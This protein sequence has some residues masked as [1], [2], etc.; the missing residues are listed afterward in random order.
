MSPWCREGWRGLESFQSVNYKWINAIFRKSLWWDRCIQNAGK[1]LASAMLWTALQIWNSKFV[2]LWEILKSMHLMIE[3]QCPLLRVH[4]RS[5]DEGRCGRGHWIMVS[6]RRGPCPN[7]DLAIPKNDQ[8][9]AQ[10]HHHDYINS[11][12]TNYRSRTTWYYHYFTS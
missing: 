10:K 9:S 2:M 12:N 8:N 11:S 5:I 3:I 7:S 6:F 4:S 1:L